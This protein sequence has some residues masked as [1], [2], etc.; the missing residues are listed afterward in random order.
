MGLTKPTQ[1]RYSETD[2]HADA[3]PSP[4]RGP[5]ARASKKPSAVQWQRL[6]SAGTRLITDVGTSR[7]AELS[8]RFCGPC[9]LLVITGRST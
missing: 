3:V 6:G 7:G 9:R 1:R 8:S 2:H 4:D 5:N